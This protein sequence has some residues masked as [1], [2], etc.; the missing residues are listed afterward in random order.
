MVLTHCE[1]IRSR[2]QSPHGSALIKKCPYKEAPE[3]FLASIAREDRRN[4]KSATG[5]R[6]CI[7]HDRAGTLILGSQFPE[8]RAV[9]AVYKL[10]GLWCLFYTAWKDQNK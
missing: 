8:L 2:R 5:K 6:A 4:Q 7:K 1:V 9:F 3:S 10:P